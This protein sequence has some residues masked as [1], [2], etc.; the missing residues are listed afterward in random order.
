M[1]KAVLHEWEDIGSESRLVELGMKP[2]AVF[3]KDRLAAVGV[4]TGPSLEAS[5][6]R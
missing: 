5:R 2:C 3:Y 4:E 1:T 6:S